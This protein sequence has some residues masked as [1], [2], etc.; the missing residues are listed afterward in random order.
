MREKGKKSGMKTINSHVQ[1]QQTLSA[2]NMNKATPGHAIVKLLKIND[3]EKLLKATKE[4]HVF[5]TMEQR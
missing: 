4:R 2:R 5:F 1:V 3:K